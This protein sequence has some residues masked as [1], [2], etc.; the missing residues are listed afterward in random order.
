MEELLMKLN[1]VRKHNEVIRLKREI[2]QKES[3][4]NA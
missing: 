4:N 2:S 3:E 1:M